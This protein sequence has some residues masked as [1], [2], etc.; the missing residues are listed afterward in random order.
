MNVPTV[1]VAQQ[2]GVDKILQTAK[3]LGITTLVEEGA[4]SDANLAM[5]SAA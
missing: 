4:Y 5:H 2:V 1:L 3:N